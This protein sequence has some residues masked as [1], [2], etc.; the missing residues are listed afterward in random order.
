MRRGLFAIVTILRQTHVKFGPGD[1]AMKIMPMIALLTLFPVTALAGA[2]EEL[3][4]ADKAFSDMSVAN[5]QATAF[6]AYI[7]DDAQLFGAGGEP[8]IGRK[9][10]EARYASEKFKN[11]ASAKGTLE[12]QPIEAFASG[13]GTLGWTNGHWKFTG[14]ADEKGVRST[15][16]GHYIT[17]WRRDAS[18]AWKVEADIGTIDEPKTK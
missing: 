17:I 4:E 18:G 8:V 13:D 3:I 15:S 6:L 11:S 5:G 9:A 14:P 7:A 2:K 1:F 12:W 16:T 10:A